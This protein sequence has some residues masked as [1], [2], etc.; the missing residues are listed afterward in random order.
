M[1]ALSGKMSE[2]V[3]SFC[4]RI[5]ADAML[6]QCAGGNVSWKDGDVLWIKA[7]GNWLADAKT[8]DIFVPTDLPYLRQAIVQRDFSAAPLVVGSS[9]LRPSIET[10]LHVVMPHTVV[11]HLH[12]IEALAYLVRAN[13]KEKLAHA[14]GDAL[15]WTIVDYF[16]PGA[17]LAEA[18]ADS[19]ASFSEAHIVFLKNHGLVIGGDT[20]E[21]VEEALSRL[22]H[23][24]RND[25]MHSLAPTV[26]RQLHIPG[27]VLS[28]DHGINALSA[29]PE[30]Y[31]RLAKDWALYPDHVVFLGAEPVVV[32]RQDA[33]HL[34][35]ASHGAPF[36]F[37]SGF[38][39]FE[40]K[41]V[42]LAQAAQLRCYYDV[43]ARQA[44][45][46]PLV[47][48]TKAQIAELMNWEAEKFR[49]GLNEG[50]AP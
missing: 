3:R 28:G 35:P 39:T 1:N 24:L 17:A 13:A 36:I 26:D 8:K 25:T 4:A 21:S 46:E 14:L 12:A 48:L 11:I 2:K 37:V 27:Y 41:S 49:T 15:S 43:L 32:D 29:Q 40:K 16:K 10:L 9:S 44:P 45:T 30:Y 5:G 42:T 23:L 33:K 50:T 31:S 38:G 6:V 18:V 34:D 7:S 47:A 20:M 22:T 19:I